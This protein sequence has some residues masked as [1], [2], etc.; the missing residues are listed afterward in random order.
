LFGSAMEMLC[1]GLV[2]GGLAAATGELS[3]RDPGP[4]S[5]LAKPP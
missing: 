4:I 5:G 3:R 2:L 1:G